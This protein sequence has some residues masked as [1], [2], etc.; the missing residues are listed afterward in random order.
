VVQQLPY[1][2]DMAPC[3]FWLFCKLKMAL[4]GKRFN[5]ID[6]VKENTTKHLSIILK[7]LF[8]KFSNNGRTAGISA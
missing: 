1:A 4:K 8:K 5:D 6:T 3:D 7:D 2:H